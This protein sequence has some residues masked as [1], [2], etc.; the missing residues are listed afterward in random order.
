MSS[1]NHMVPNSC[2]G[3]ALAIHWSSKRI[4]C[5]HPKT[6]FKI[7]LIKPLID[8]S[9]Q[10]KHILY[11]I[12]ECRHQWW[13]AFN[14]RAIQ[15]CCL[16]SFNSNYWIESTQLHFLLY[17]DKF[18]HHHVLNLKDGK[19]DIQMKN[20]PLLFHLCTICKLE[21]E[22]LYLVAKPNIFIH[23]RLKKNDTLSRLLHRCNKFKL[24]YKPLY[25]IKIPYVEFVSIY[26]GIFLAIQFLKY[27]QKK[28][29]NFKIFL[30]NRNSYLLNVPVITN[31]GSKVVHCKTR[32]ITWASFSFLECNETSFIASDATFFNAFVIDVM[33]RNIQQTYNIIIDVKAVKSIDNLVIR[34]TVLKSGLGNYVRDNLCTYIFKVLR[35]VVEDP[36]YRSHFNSHISACNMQYPIMN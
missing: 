17:I 23:L 18:L 32:W 13:V 10:L 30:I 28:L 33:Y 7:K 31:K 15:N 14:W 21:L 35:K 5:S 12:A 2:K 20:R 27:H 1:L 29:I 16:T 6:C 3:L 25:K 26:S 34:N 36:I 19:T 8:G 4:C 11:R 24:N 9:L 22:S